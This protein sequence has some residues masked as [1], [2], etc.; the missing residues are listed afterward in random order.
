M[1]QLHNDISAALQVAAEVVKRK[2]PT[3]PSQLFTFGQQVWLEET[4]VKTTHPK[5]KLVPRCHGPFKILHTTPIN[6]K[7][8]LP[9]LWRIHPVF[10]NLLLSPYKETMEHGQ[11]FNR[12]PSDVVEGEDEHYEIETIVDA[13]PT[14]NR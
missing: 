10:H 2:G 11:N 5:A 3:S 14:P 1:D 13:R 4:N 12:P 9:P 7:L 8:Q 6:S